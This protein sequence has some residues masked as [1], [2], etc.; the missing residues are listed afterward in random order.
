MNFVREQT[1]V[2]TTVLSTDDGQGG[3]K[4]EYFSGD[5]FAETPQQV[6][7]DKVVDLQLFHPDSSA[8]TPPAGM[9]YFSVRWTGFLT[10]A[11]SGTYQL[12]LSGSIKRL[13]VYG[14]M[15]GGDPPLDAPTAAPQNEQIPLGH[16]SAFKNEV[17]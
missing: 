16:R 17:L 6:R 15:V 10:P 2:P 3:L 13:W 7:V 8:L 12:R 4:A 1:V 11:E 9:K 14:Q 5:N